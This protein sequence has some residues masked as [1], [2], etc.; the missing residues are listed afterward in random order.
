M[1]PLCS[2]SVWTTPGTCAGCHSLTSDL[3]AFATAR[4][5]QPESRLREEG[6]AAS[7]GTVKRRQDSRHPKMQNTPVIHLNPGRTNFM[8]ATP[9]HS[10]NNGFD[11]ITSTQAYLSAPFA[12]V[13]AN[14]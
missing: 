3:S 10:E 9:R 4:N 12:P 11:E 8:S 6:S 13:A 5:C 14:D 2:R 7:S 1:R